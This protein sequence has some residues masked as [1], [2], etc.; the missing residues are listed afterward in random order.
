MS[1]RQSR[2]RAFQV[3]FQIDLGRTEPE[4]AFSGMDSS[5]GK[6]TDPD[7]AK[8]LVEGTLT[9]ISVINNAIKNYSKDWALQR[10]AYV[11]RSIIRLA[12]YE[13]LFCRD[14]PDS[15]A[16]NEAVELGKTF[17]SDESGKFINGVLGRVLEHKDEILSI[18]ANN[19]RF[20]E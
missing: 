10:M 13:I 17:G 15:V 12:M 19:T 3:L 4:V 20:G 11:D 1:R 18:A 5:F 9:N 16:I 8:E 14:T 7:F 2:E 6:L